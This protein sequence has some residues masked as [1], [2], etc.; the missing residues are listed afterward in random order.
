M[1]LQISNDHARR[2][3][4]DWIDRMGALYLAVSL[5]PDFAYPAEAGDAA[6]AAGQAMLEQAP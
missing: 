4:R 2:F 3:L 1:T 5:P 6:A